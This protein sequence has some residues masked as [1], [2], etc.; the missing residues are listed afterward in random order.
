MVVLLI[1]CFIFTLQAKES[2]ILAKKTVWMQ[3]QKAKERMKLDKKLYSNEELFE[4]EEL[5]MGVKYEQDM[6]IAEKNL[7][8]L[9]T[10]FSQANRTGCA[11]L[12]YTQR[13]GGKKKAKNL[14]KA[15]RLYSDC[16]YAD[17]VQVG[18]LA[19]YLLAR[20]YDRLNKTEK[21]NKL[22]LSLRDEY[23]DAVDH[24]G[25]LLSSKINYHGRE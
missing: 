12:Y 17:G 9:M 11:L 1:T 15:I 22:Y 7:K 20:Y 23:P 5:Y 14:I 6:G 3:K 2:K 4:I 18:A 24:L 21:A 19:R 13:C 8:L 25:S 16:F 10:K